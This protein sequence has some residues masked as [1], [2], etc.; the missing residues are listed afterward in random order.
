LRR[1][2]CTLLRL[3]GPLEPWFDKMWR[4]S[5]MEVSK[6]MMEDIEITSSGVTCRA[7]LC[8]SESE[9]LRNERGCPVLVL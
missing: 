5:E 2:G 3:F 7:W 4:P 6:V 1:R 8:P 9:A